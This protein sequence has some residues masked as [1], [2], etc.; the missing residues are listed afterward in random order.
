MKVLTI[1]TVEFSQN[2]ITSVIMNYY[3]ALIKSFNIQMDF[4]G[5]SDIDSCYGNELKKNKAHYT[6]I[7]NRKK[8]PFHYSFHLYKI[9]KKITMILSM[10]MA[11][12]E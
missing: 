2:G 1:S 11:V 3:K 10:Y 12:V 9:I 7:K 6:Y 4:V 5:Q 8:N